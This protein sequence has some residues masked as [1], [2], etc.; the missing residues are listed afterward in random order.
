MENK[1][2]IIFLIIVI[3]LVICLFIFPGKEENLDIQ[4]KLSAGEIMEMIKTDKDYDDLSEFIKDFEPEVANYIKLG[5]DEYRKIRPEWQEQGFG[6]RIGIV[7]KINLTASCYW[8]ELE[9]KK[10]ETKGLRMILDVEEGKS[11]LLVAS[12]SIKAGVGL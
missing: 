1:N 10:D 2:L 8:I 12:L 4:N 11:L 5:E 6:D 7:D 3:L 9:N